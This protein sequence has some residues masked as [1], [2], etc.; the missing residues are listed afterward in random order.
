MSRKFQNISNN[1]LEIVRNLIK[2]E[3]ID[4]IINDDVT[5]LL[6]QKLKV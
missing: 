3:N 4:V 6:N 2:M 5:Q 1:S